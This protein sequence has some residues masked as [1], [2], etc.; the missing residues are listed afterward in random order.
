MVNKYHWVSANYKPLP[1][2][3]NKK[4]LAEPAASAFNEMKAAA[5]KE[6]YTLKAIST[7]R[8]YAYQEKLFNRYA[9]NDG[10]EA[11]SRY[12]ARAGQ[13]EHQTGLAVDVTNGM[14]LYQS[15]AD[16]AEGKWLWANAYKFGFILR[17]PRGKEAITGYMFEPWH[18]RYVGKELAAEFGPNTTLTLEEHMQGIRNP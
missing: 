8:T 5:A 4:A 17:Y 16:T 7:Y 10:I 12:S 15:F 13:S 9:A 3:M 2:S 1:D 6:G 14:G 18:Y 11:A